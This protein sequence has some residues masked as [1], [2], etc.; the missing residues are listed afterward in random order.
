MRICGG[1]LELEG[2]VGVQRGVVEG[3]SRREKGSDDNADE[4]DDPKRCG[5]RPKPY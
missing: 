2:A 1:E 4:T 3:L 5:R